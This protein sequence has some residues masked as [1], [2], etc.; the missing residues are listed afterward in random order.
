ME[1]R[2][3]S[4]LPIIF[5]LSLAC[6]VY[7][8]GLWNE[9]TNQ[10][11]SAGVYS[12]GQSLHA[13]FYNSLDSIGF[14]SIDKPPLGLWIQVLFT[15][16]FGFSGLVLL[17]PQAIAG[18]LSVYFIYRMINK[19][20]GQTAAIISAL[21]LTFTP[22]FAAISRNN[23]M[24]G[25]LILMLVLASDQA[26]KAAE[27]GSLKHLLFAGVLIGLGFNV[28]MLQ[29]YMIILAVYLTYLFFSKEK[30]LKRIVSCALSV[31]L[32]LIVSFSWVIAVDLT[33]A[34]NRP[35]VGS[36]GTNSALML[37][38]GYNG[39]GRLD[40]GLAMDIGKS[41]GI[42][43]QGVNLP[44]PQK[45]LNS[46]SDNG[47][48]GNNAQ[49]TSNVDPTRPQPQ[50]MSGNGNSGPSEGGSTSILRLF[51]AENSGQIS[52]F[53]LLA[54]FVSLLC[55]YQL[56]KKKLKENNNNITTFYF[57]MCFIPMFIYFSL[58][59]GMVHRYYLAMLSFVIA[60]LVGIGFTILNEKNK[61]KN[62]LLPIAFSI[63][64]VT[65]LYIQSLY[66]N[67]LS[68][69]LPVTAIIFAASAIAMFL[70]RKK[71]IANKIIMSLMATLLLLPA[72]WS[73]TPVIYGGDAK[74]P[75]AGPELVKQKDPFDNQRD[76]SK[77][78]SYLKENRE[79][80][81][82]LATAPSSMIGGQLIL[83]SGQPVMC[84]GGFN[85][86]DTP[87]TVE[88]FKSYIKSNKV[89]Y[90]VVEANSRPSPMGGDNKTIDS[91]IVENCKVVD[92]QFDGITLYKLI[93]E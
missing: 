82:Y 80:A 33:P 34:E 67:W 25:I 48:N 1:N 14:I 16:V 56:F 92:R 90:A 65:Q 9:A 53:L 18:V 36:S 37:A 5:V 72:L 19:R 42:F 85:G 46:A 6:F 50:Q 81:N 2:L 13:F 70:I 17:L 88:E 89:K 71:E 27:K 79:D 45:G 58:L 66:D 23:T 62:I 41:T 32:M 20:F 30:F 26:I 10:Y 35:Y 57:V 55:M 38:F 63:T 69:V 87:L 64:A 91:W 40:T 3:K 31:M 4:K 22:I 51:N 21:A 11:Y 29:A 86:S 78:I 43:R 68:C 73:L 77:L 83:Q 28:K 39:I 74:L 7:M 44:P 60:P 54:I 84:L 47:A 24:D 12:M 59:N 8:W 49:I 93:V 61:S 75:I 52:W 15:K 76:F